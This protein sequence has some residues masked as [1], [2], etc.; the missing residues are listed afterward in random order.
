M[1]KPIFGWAFLYL[2]AGQAR[3]Q[4]FYILTLQS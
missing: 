1:K 3:L 2:F 4:D